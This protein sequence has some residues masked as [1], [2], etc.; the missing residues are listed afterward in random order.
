[1]TLQEIVPLL[2]EEYQIWFRVR[3]IYY[4]QIVDGSKTCEVRRASDYWG[5][6]VLAA[7]VQLAA[8]H[9]VIAIFTCGNDRH[10]RE[11]LS[12]E[13][14]EKANQALGREPSAQGLVDIGRGPVYR[15]NLGQEL[16]R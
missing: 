11:I 9:R 2:K 4:V 12:I 13:R 1:M 8:G 16:K 7:N 6:Y 14:F 10:M 15:F 3:R 5:R